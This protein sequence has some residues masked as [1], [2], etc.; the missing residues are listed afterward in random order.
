[1]R[2]IIPTLFLLALARATAA[3]QCSDADKKALE[4]FDKAWSEATTRGDRAQLQTIIADD[5]ASATLTGTVNKTAT[6]DVAV[7]TAERNRANPQSVARTTYDN[8]V[9][10]CTPVS[11]TVTHR[12]T[13]TSTV[14][15]REQTTYSRS[16]HVMEKRSGRWQ[17]VSNAGHPLT[18]AQI[19]TYLEQD[20]NEAIK[21]RD[22]AW[23][24]RNY[25]D[26]A[27]DVSSASGNLQTKAQAIAD[28]RRADPGV[29]ESLELSEV[30]VRIDGNAAVVTGVYRDR[31][32]EDDGKPYDRRV[33]FTD[34]WLKRD[35]RWMVWAT[36]GT[37]IRQ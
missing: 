18:D 10:T 28:L 3:A 7:A 37:P 31:G 36:Q 20:W 17:V 6:I 5:F 24:E 11:G 15:G 13:I 29:V 14:N 9:I 25:L 16:V 12:N 21:K 33:R 19:L 35:G 8:Y 26:D 4:A 23:I 1:M 34:I 27:T 22:A 32:R 30:V 2:H